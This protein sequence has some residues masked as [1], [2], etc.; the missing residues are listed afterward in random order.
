MSKLSFTRK[1]MPILPD[2]R[3]MYKL[4]IILLIL[5]LSSRS[6]KS[7]LI[8]LHLLNWVL[9][10]EKR[11]SKLLFCAK[12][13]FL[14]FKVWG[15]DPA[16]NISLEIAQYE[17]LIEKSNLSFKLTDKGIQYITEVVKQDIF[18]STIDYLKCLGKS[19][20]EKM[21]NEIIGAWK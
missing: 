10:D 3:P 20:T 21:I 7:S 9:K 14:D 4:T 16:L 15:I 2:H 19:I 5:Y 6:Y 11:K 12:E 1:P 17:G 18:Q 13:K 8:R